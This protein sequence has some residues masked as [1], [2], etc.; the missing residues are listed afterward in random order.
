MYPYNFSAGPA[1]LPQAVIKEAAQGVLDI[2][3]TGLSILEVSHRGADVVAIMQEAESLLREL[4]GISDEYAVLFLSGGASSQFYMVPMNIL[5][6]GQTA[7][8]ID[9]GTWSTK[10]IKEAKYFGEVNTIA[11]SKD[12]GYSYVPKDYD[13]SVEGR[14]C[15]ITTNNTIF[16]TQFSELPDTEI[17]LVGDASSDFLSRPMDINKFD[18]LYAGAQKNLGPAG[19]TVVIVKKEIVG[20]FERA[21]PTM[22]NY[23]THIN[24]G[25]A[26]NTPPVFPIYVSMLTM[27]WLKSLGGLDVMQKMNQ[28][29]AGILYE[30]IDRNPL[31]KGVADP[32]DRSLMNAT[33]VCNQ[34]EHSDVFLKLCSENGINGIKGHRSVGGFRASIYN[35]MPI[36]GIKHLIEKMQE[37]ENHV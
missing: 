18:V 6:S 2:N 28:E 16:G 36:D 17:P 1:I 21:I 34:E 15:H 27:R 12:K 8:Y 20:Q 35:A 9:T 11:S 26:F 19:V 13:R 25:S 31:F 30:E 4:Y 14:Y 24:K 23:Q 3:Q 37:L 33:F 32:N 29:K 7:L 22:L 5:D 10:A